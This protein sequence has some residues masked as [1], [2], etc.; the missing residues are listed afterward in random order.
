MRCG[1]PLA[2]AR[3]SVGSFWRAP[4][5][6]LRRESFQ[7]AF[8]AAAQSAA[9]GGTL[10]MSLWW[11][12]PDSRASPARPGS[13][14]PGTG[15]V[16]AVLA[17]EYTEVAGHM[18]GGPLASIDEI[19][20]CPNLAVKGVR[21]QH[22]HGRGS[23]RRITGARVHNVGIEP[24]VGAKELFVAAGRGQRHILEEHLRCRDVWMAGVADIGRD[25]KSV[26]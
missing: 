16:G 24:A 11:T 9:R 25:R 8:C 4:L 13:R 14:N 26:V 10:R 18:L 3:G 12:F 5:T 2:D 6:R 22:R 19:R 20:F 15:I 23:L 17:E 7:A 21:R 1:K